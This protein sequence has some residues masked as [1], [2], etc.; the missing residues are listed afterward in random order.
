MVIV[1]VD[2]SLHVLV[3]CSDMCP[4]YVD[5]QQMGV[6]DVHCVSIAPSTC[7]VYISLVLF[8]I[9]GGLINWCIGRHT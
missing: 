8:V 3:Q 9:F 2:I 6:C 5:F 7:N 1:A 4:V